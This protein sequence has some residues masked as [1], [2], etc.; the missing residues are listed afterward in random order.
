MLNIPVAIFAHPLY[1][2]IQGSV[3]KRELV[4]LMIGV[5]A[6]WSYIGWRIDTRRATPRPNS[7]LRTFAVILGCAFALIVLIEAI[8]MFHAGILYKSVA[9]C[10]SVLMFRHFVLLLRTSHDVPEKTD[11]GRH[12]PPITLVSVALSWAVFLIIGALA[13]PPL[14]SSGA[15]NATAAH[16]VAVCGGCLL[17]LTAY[18]V[19][20]YF[21]TLW[22][23]AAFVPDKSSYVVWICFETGLAVAAVAAMVYLVVHRWLS[24]NLY[25]T[26]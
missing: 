24:K 11:I 7:T 12:L 4:A 26:H 8:S 18:A 6:L 22:R 20:V 17:L 10:W 5:M 15:P 13:L 16:V 3:R 21:M 25:Y 23:K 9:I 19:V 2:L 14:D 1:H